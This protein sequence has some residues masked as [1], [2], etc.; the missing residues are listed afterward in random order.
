MNQLETW[1]IAGAMRGIK[2]FNYPL[3]F[4]AAEYLSGICCKEHIVNPA[5][6]DGG[7]PPEP[8]KE[9]PLAT[10]M[11]RD[12]PLVAS[13]TD[14]L[15]LPGWERSQGARIELTVALACGVR[16]HAAI[17][18]GEGLVV[19]HAPLAVR[20]EAPAASPQPPPAGEVRLTDPTTG[21]EKGA[22]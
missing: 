22:P 3:F 21:A 20:A 18:R 13:A 15:L 2:D 14:I 16:P 17:V 10:Y 7:V 12:L 4:A 11:R 19:G 9:L 1:Y 6:L 5:N 8:G